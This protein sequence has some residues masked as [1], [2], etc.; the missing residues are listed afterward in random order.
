MAE[1]HQFVQSAFYAFTQGLAKASVYIWLAWLV[2]LCV[3]MLSGALARQIAL[4]YEAA[5]RAHAPI[6]TF[7]CLR[8]LL[9]SASG[10]RWGWRDALG[11][12]LMFGVTVLCLHIQ[13]GVAGLAA[14][15]ACAVLFCL[16]YI[17]IRT[18]L[19]PDALTLPL[20]GLGVW[21]GPLN[22]LAALSAAML[23]YLSARLLDAAYRRVRGQAGMGGGDIK[24][25][26]ALAAWTGGYTLIWIVLGACLG[27]LLYA[28]GAQRRLMPYG[29]YPF[30]PFL[31]LSAAPVLV[32]G[33]QSWF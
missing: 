24:L 9:R 18:G 15:L 17:D 20:L 33:V 22:G 5:L 28:M 13:G 2:A 16:A 4:N 8:V 10:M 23:T 19:L 29:A 6:N 27:G 7:T 25:M 32:A 3:G 11:A 14:S 1:F 26:A 30:G 12:G 31:A 21:I